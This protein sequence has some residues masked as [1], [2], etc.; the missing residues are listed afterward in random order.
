MGLLGQ[1]FEWLAK[2]YTNFPWS[3]SFHTGFIA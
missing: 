3:G 2:P 1:I